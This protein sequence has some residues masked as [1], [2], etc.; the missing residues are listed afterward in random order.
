MPATAPS[1]AKPVSDVLL[2]GAG[3]MSATLGVLLKALD[4]S[5]TMAGFE[6]LEDK[7]SAC[8]AT[9]ERISG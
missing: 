6:R 2:I 1:S 5:I 3:I 8:G 9:I 4:P 7:L